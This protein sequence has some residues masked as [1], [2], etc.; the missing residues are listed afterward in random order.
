MRLQRLLGILAVLLQH[1][2]VSAESMAERFEVSTR[3]IYRDLETLEQA[4]VPIVA[5]PGVN[6]GIEILDTYKLDKTVFLSEDFS[7]I[8][9]GLQSISGAVDTAKIN[10]T[11]AKLRALIPEPQAKG[12]ELSGQ[13]L[14]VDL[15]PW[16][17]HPD[18]EPIFNLVKS[19]LEQDKLLK[20]TYSDKESTA[21]VRIVEPHQLVLKEQSWYLRAFCLERQAFRTFL[22]RRINSAEILEEDFSPRPF[23][24]ELEDFK[25]W[26]HPKAIT[27]ELVADPSM[28]QMV[29]Q[30]CRPECLTILPDGNLRIN[31]PFVESEAGYGVLL[32]MGHKCR[33]ISPEHVKSELRRRISLLAAQYN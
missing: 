2:R 30:Y 8:I 6:G 21:S 15:K 27:V 1:Q 5:Y 28:R 9:A 17:I 11:L 16:S 3:T 10:R 25:E 22:L 14:Y 26:T 12:I 4:G 24:H 32:Q 31:L 23:T 7:S 13:K 20:L 18:F 29:L 33:V 19:A